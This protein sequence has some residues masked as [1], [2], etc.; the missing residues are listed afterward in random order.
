LVVY[1]GRRTSG[2][3]KANPKPADP[4]VGQPL[5]WL[6][7][8]GQPN[9]IPV[10]MVRGSAQASGAACH[11]IAAR[12]PHPPDRL[13]GRESRSLAMVGPAGVDSRIAPPNA[14]AASRSAKLT[15][16]PPTRRHAPGY[17]YHPSSRWGP[18]RLRAGTPNAV[19]VKRKHLQTFH[20]QLILRSMCP[21]S[22]SMR[23]VPSSAFR[24][25]ACNGHRLAFA[26]RCDRR[27]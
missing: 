18:Q 27:A 3:G 22:L 4:T 24:T 20:G 15:S 23:H 8:V 1:P 14:P 9:M 25:D 10:S 16:R 26:C 12:P 2:E 13:R 6:T 17:Y 5:R 19:S 11:A 21:P 7:G